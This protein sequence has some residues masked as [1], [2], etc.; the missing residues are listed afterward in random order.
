V[1]VPPDDPEALAE[2]LRRV[3]DDPARRA[4]LVAAGR[5]RADEFSLDYLADAF[6]ERYELAIKQASTPI[7]A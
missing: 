3:L 2:A 1:L 6:V 4:A 5:T 7:P